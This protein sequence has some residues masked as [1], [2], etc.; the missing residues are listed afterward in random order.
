MS[1]QTTDKKSHFVAFCNRSKRQHKIPTKLLEK[2]VFY[3]KYFLRDGERE[4]EREKYEY[5]I[6]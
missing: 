1:T 5:Y 6:L 3:S 4:S 2:C